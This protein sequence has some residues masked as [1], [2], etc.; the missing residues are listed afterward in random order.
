MRTPSVRWSAS[1]AVV[2]PVTRQRDLTTLLLLLRVTRRE[3]DVHHAVRVKSALHALLPDETFPK[4]VLQRA[5]APKV[6]K[7]RRVFQLQGNN[8]PAPEVGAMVSRV[9]S[10]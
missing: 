1:L 2:F 3:T 7:N 10:S 5:L 8:A 6:A 4:N 9:V